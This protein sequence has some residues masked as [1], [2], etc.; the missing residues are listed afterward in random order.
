ML[1]KPKVQI[2]SKTLPVSK[3]NISY[4]PFTVGEEKIL[5]IAAE[6]NE[7][8]EIMDAF[9]QV[10]SNC[11]VED[12]KV[13]KL[14][15]FDLEF[16]F[17]LIRSVAVNEIATF[18]YQG[19][20]VEMDIRAALDEAA[21]NVVVPEKRIQLTEDIGVIMK[22]MTLDLFIESAREDKGL[23]E[24]QII[25]RTLA[26]MI[27]SIY[28]ADNVYNTE[29]YTIDE[30]LDFIDSMPTDVLQK[31]QSYIESLPKLRLTTEYVD[32]TGEKQTLVLEGLTD[33][34]QYV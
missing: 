22:D 3:Q 30:V 21:A 5:L 19:S 7:Q 17:I 2:R 13:G 28:D 10:L 8:S 12:I 31:L 26:R 18:Q 25:M 16:L 23:N 15:L 34:F 20:S 14:P 33:F 24:T 4:Q 32:R 9:K 1:P 29:D 27:D 6:S 11:I